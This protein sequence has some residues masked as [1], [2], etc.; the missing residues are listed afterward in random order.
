[1]AGRAKRLKVDA[2]SV[3]P[4]RIPRADGTG[5]SYATRGLRT[6]S[7]VDL[8]AP[9]AND[10]QAELPLPRGRYGATRPGPRSNIVGPDESPGAPTP[11]ARPLRV[12]VVAAGMSGL[13]AARE[14]YRAG[15]DVPRT[16]PGCPLSQV[17]W[18][19]ATKPSMKYDVLLPVHMAVQA[20]APIGN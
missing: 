7:D 16:L 15:H 14:L 6:P 20:R 4:A 5:G 13:A 9:A 12:V 8:A 1:M 11:A 19:L 10:L 18:G 2:R 17:T 3:E